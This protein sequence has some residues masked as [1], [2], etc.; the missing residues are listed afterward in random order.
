MCEE[1]DPAH[2][3][4]ATAAMLLT[5]LA[6]CGMVRTGCSSL[7][8]TWVV[9]HASSFLSIAFFNFFATFFFSSQNTIFSQKSRLKCEFTIYRRSA[10][11]MYAKNS[12]EFCSHGSIS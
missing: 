12:T 5:K 8:F 6:Q 7:F 1:D 3:R 2:K 11:I 10:M 4:N 9:Y